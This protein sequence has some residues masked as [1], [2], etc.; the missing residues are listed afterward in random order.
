MKKIAHLLIAF[1][2]LSFACA[3]SRAAQ[4]NSL[5]SDNVVLQQN[6]PLPIW[7]TG[8]DGEKIEVTLG[9]H[10][11]TATV[12]GGKWRVRLDALP[13]GGPYTLTVRGDN[14]LTVGNVLVGE[15]WVC[16]GQS[17]MERQLG[18]RNGQ[19]LLENWQ[20]EAAAAD[21]PQIRM[22]F[23]ARNPA[24]NPVE[25]AHG[26]W[27]VCSPATVKDFS[28][29]G[30]FFARALQADLKVPVGMIFSAVGGT[31]VE[32]WTS[33]A[34]LESVPAGAELLRKAD[35]DIREFPAKLAQ[36]K[37]DEPGLLQKYEQDVAAAAAAGK[38]AP[39]KP[40]APAD[41]TNKHPSGLFNG[42]IAPLMPCAI[43]G[44]IWYQ[45]E[46]NGGRGKQYRT[47]F[48]LMI[49]DWRSRWQQGDVPF[50]F[51]QL[52]TYRASDPM[53]REAQFLALTRVAQTAMVVT[54]DVGD[55]SD[56]HPTR[57][58]PVGVRLALAARAVAYHEKIEFSGPLFAASEFKDGK[59]I[60]HFSHANGLTAKGG[61]LTGFV[62]AGAD[63]K[64]VPA[65]AVIHGDTV[66]VNSP[67]VSAPTA[68]RYNWAGVADGNLFN[69]ADLPASPFRTDAE[70]DDQ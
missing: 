12:S 39:K 13:A 56:I 51:V 4:L 23:V 65:D 10:S 5:F 58:V 9:N 27:V 37:T 50:C 18:P 68:V 52:A 46:S 20:Q 8:S 35:Q 60:L 45:G 14:A 16:S 1:A 43:R 22:F 2:A 47:L 34:A 29:V 70:P 62:I 3:S 30:F 33:Q 28:A 41:P 54:T 17:N 38:P 59:V 19:K 24:P 36:Y 40:S 55:A 7:G 26:K 31:P 57:K 64:W 61:V 25:D 21:F 53:I 66:V 15:V 49:R 63:R 48:P 6:K 44:V 11:A 32:A 67:T 69:S 42:M